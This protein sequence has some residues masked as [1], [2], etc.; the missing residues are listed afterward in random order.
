MNKINFVFGVSLGCSIVFELLK[1]NDIQIDSVIL[2]GASTCESSFTKS[3]LY[4]NLIIYLKKLTK[5]SK[6]MVKKLLSLKYNRKMSSIILE[7]MKGLSKESI[8]NMVRDYYCTEHPYLRRKVQKNLNFYYGSRDRNI[9]LAE[10]RLKKI[11]PKANFY[12]WP[13]FKHCEKL[14]REPR[15]YAAILKSFL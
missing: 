13:Y 15:S 5:I 6:D 1:Y 12:K 10:K 14:Y 11:Y 2:E 3:F 4:S 8:K 7:E 9:K